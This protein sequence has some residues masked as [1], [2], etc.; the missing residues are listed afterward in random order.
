M[1]HVMRKPDFCVCENKGA[2]QLYSC[3]TNQ[4]LCFRNLD[5]AIPLRNFKILAYFWDYQS[6]CVGPGRKSVRPVF[7]HCGSITL[8]SIDFICVGCSQ[9]HWLS[10]D[11]PVC[12]R[13]ATSWENKIITYVKTKVQISCAVTVIT[14]G[15]TKVQISCAVTVN[16]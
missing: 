13:W 16:S 9:S 6:V 14:Y 10:L 15:K 4:H 7:L 3:T 11:I 2:D 1:S 12:I 8:T 5:S